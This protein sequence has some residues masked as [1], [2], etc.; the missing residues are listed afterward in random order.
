MI[1]SEVF[2]WRSEFKRLEGAYAPATMR[3][4]DADVEAF[5]TWCETC[6]R[7]TLRVLIRCRKSAPPY[8]EGS[9][10]YTSRATADLVTTWMDWRG[11]AIF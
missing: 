5:Q 7:A 2:N 9:I 10:A 6:G 3:S 11:P 4:Y 8:G 1:C